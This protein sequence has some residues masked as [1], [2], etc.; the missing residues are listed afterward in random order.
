MNPVQNIR[1]KTAANTAL[2]GDFV[3]NEPTG[4]MLEIGSVP[5]TPN[6]L[7]AILD[8][9]N[10][11]IRVLT[12]EAAKAGMKR[13]YFQDL[14]HASAETLLKN[15]MDIPRYRAFF[16]PP[17]KDMWDVAAYFSVCKSNQV[18]VSY[19]DPDH[20]LESVRRLYILAPFLFMITDNSSAFAEGRPVSGHPGMQYRTALGRRGGVPDYVFTAQTGEEYLR[21]HI[22]HVMNNALFVYYNEE[23]ELL[24]LPENE[25]LTFQDLR[26]RGLNTATNYFFSE[27]VLW[28]DV[29]IAALKDENGQVINHRYESRMWGVGIHQ[30]QS[31]LLITAALAFNAAF[32]KKTDQLVS[33]FGFEAGG[34]DQLREHLQSAYRNARAHDG[35]FLD[36]SYGTGSMSDFARQFADLLEEA[37]DGQGFEGALAPILSICRTGLTDA[38]IN[39]LMFPT[40]EELNAFQRTYDPAL[41]NDPE[42]CA[43]MLFE[44]EL[45]VALQRSPRCA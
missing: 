41:F 2:G 9:T 14:P 26:E 43:L 8:D 17:R 15:L 18:S 13:S 16:G 4:D 22:H 3:R 10:R 7:Q 11:K 28:P 21:D 1:V 36:I 24:R 20:M 31:A 45:P 25:W 44:K 34:V 32:S 37:Y 19:R 6:D 23:G 5:G 38:K 29:K 35:A 27:S 40:L 42:R 12:E 33:S 30:H 39:R